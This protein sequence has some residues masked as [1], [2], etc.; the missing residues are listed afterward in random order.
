[1]NA[2]AVSFLAAAL[3]SFAALHPAAAGDTASPAMT[4]ETAAP[5]TVGGLT[6]EGAWSKAMLPGQKVGGG[7]LTIANKGS[8]DDKLISAAS[9]VSPS[10]QIHEMAVVNDVMEMRQLTDSLVIPAG[11]T[12]EF[13]PGGLHLMFMDVPEPFKEGG[14]VPVTLTFEKAGVAEVMLPIA[15]AGAREMPEGPGHMGH[16]G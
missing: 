1:M 6:I 12:V 13:K 10:V 16:G 5:V 14:T 8:A 15:P 2:K 4:A 11:Q 3:V 7:F 9:P